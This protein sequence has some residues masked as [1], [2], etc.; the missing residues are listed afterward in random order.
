[1]TKDGSTLK[2]KYGQSLFKEVSLNRR[3][4]DAG[5]GGEYCAC[6]VPKRIPLEDANLLKAVNAVID[7]MNREIL[8][9][10]CARLML[11]EVT[12]GASTF[13]T[14]TSLLWWNYI[15]A[16]TVEPGGFLLEATVRYD[17]SHGNFSVVKDILRM[18]RITRQ[19]SCVHDAMLER[20]CYCS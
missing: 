12:A 6:S 11:R 10:Q 17:K 19:T 5:I 7:F 18:N 2:R 3:C 20:L 8:P 16:F 14:E 1:M 9:P 13:T 15:C 4:E